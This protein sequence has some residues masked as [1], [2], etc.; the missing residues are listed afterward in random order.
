MADLTPGP[1]GLFDPPA[2]GAPGIGGVVVQADGGSRG[3]PGP[4][5]FGAVVFDESGGGVL[6]ERFGFLGTTTNNVA[7]YSGVIAGLGAALALGART[8]TVR[9]D[10]KLIV[11]Q[12]NGRW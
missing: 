6:A 9:L 5:G 2:T 11:E 10:S 7:E 4:A 3:N 12:M 8:V 1:P